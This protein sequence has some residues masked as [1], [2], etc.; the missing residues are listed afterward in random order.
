M[1]KWLEDL[2]FCRRRML[3]RLFAFIAFVTVGAII[4]V[5]LAWLYS[6]GQTSNV[7][8]DSVGSMQVA[9][10]YWVFFSANHNF[11][12]DRIDWSGYTQSD[13]FDLITVAEDEPP[14]ASRI[15]SVLLAVQEVDRHNSIANGYEQDIGWPM[16]AFWCCFFWGDYQMGSGPVFADGLQFRQSNATA[17]TTLSYPIILPV[18]VLWPGFVFNAIFYGSILWL[19]RGFWRALCRSMRSWK[20]FCRTCGYDLRG[21]LLRGCPEC[22]WRRKEKDGQQPA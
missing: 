14:R 18:H 12:A 11:M 13:A 5:A 6:M 19:C 4:N 7:A 21:N 3:K 16:R 15:E 22:G 1:S 2:Q 20:G 9:G 8:S 17:G 10:G